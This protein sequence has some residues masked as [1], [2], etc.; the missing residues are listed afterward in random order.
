MKQLV[1]VNLT[2]RT[3]TDWRP[4]TLLFGERLTLALRFLK[5]TQGQ[6]IDAALD[7]T[8]LKAAIGLVDARPTGGQFAIKIGSSP[9]DGTN[10]TGALEFNTSANNLAAHLNAVSAHAAYGTARVVFASD[11]WL[12]FFGDQLAEVPLTVVNNGLWPVSFGRINAWQLDGKWVHELRLTQAPVAFT[13]ELES[14]LPPA[15]AIT[16]IQAGGMDA[17]MV[18]NEIQQLYVPPEFLGSYIIT[19]GYGKTQQ[20]SNQDGIDV[21][22]TALETAF[23]AGNFT[24]TL[25]LSN[26]P[27]IEFKGDYSGLAMDLLVAQV[28]QAPPPD[29]AFTLAL[30]S[31]ELASMLRAQPYVT[32]PLEVRIS[33]T[34]DSGFAGELVAFTLDV[35]IFA[36]TIFADLEERP[37]TDWLRPASPKTYVP[38][39]G[40]NILTGQHY[41]RHL[42][43]DG[44]A[45]AFAVA[46]GLASEDVFVVV[47]ENHSG[48]R[49]LVDG[50][51]YSATI[52]SDSQVTVMALA[53]APA[54]DAWAILVVSAQSV[55][56][57]ASDLTVTVPQVVAGG[58]YPSLQDFMDNIGSRVTTLEGILPSTG[59][60]ATT[61]QASGITIALPTTQEVLFFKGDQTKV[62]GTDGLDLTLL[63]RPPVM[64]PAVHKVSAT[65]YT[66]GSLPAVAANSLWQNNSSGAMDFG[67]GVHGGKVPVAGFFASDGRSLY[68]A[69]RSGATTSY[70][71]TGFER[72]LWRIFVNDKMLR[73]NRTLD[74]QFGLALQIGMGT[75]NAQWMLVVEKGTA[76]QD[77]TPSTTA[78]NLQNIVWDASPV[79]SQRLIL[80]G[81]RQTH[82]FGCR[83]K[84][85]LVSLADT[86]TLDTLLYG[87][88]EGNNSA[89]PSS[90][91]FA[92]RARLI[93]FDTEDALASDARGW[94]VSEIIGATDGSKPQATI[95]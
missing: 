31:A 6:E 45:T 73:V 46:H 15:P 48:G 4:P 41:Y 19:M 28:Q 59:P 29:N 69:A 22:Q 77:T 91:D 90:A 88:W 83:I 11:S 51:D 7:V 20:L 79:L 87:V 25:P 36:P 32:L 56:A 5:T 84:R 35:T 3:A 44:T 16:R 70:F 50:T 94:V 62:F 8:S 27:T 10:T 58:G 76:P 68:A 80:T 89:A 49:Q 55:A 82:I 71:P 38:F 81:N 30:D 72:E 75:S 74:V 42:V 93:E 61:S 2:T 53:G 92:L 34:D 54:S 17:S 12:I 39:G 9:S 47:R 26:R 64:L 1:S 21:I 40:D 13:S 86:L 66:S 14:A 18:W 33:G 67:R 85:A 78:T 52:D 65:S 24:V 43:G 95:S 57:W 60:A 23:G 37:V 63:G